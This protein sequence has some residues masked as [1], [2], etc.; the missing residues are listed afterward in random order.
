MSELKISN[1]MTASSGD[2]NTIDCEITNSK[3]EHIGYAVLTI[4]KGHDVERRFENAIKLMLTP[5]KKK[6]P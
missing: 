2:N 3:N 5:L 6:Q 4:K 1:V